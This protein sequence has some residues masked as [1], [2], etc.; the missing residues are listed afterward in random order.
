M[1]QQLIFLL[2]VQ[3]CKQVRKKP[4]FAWR[5]CSNGL[6]AGG[7]QICKQASKLLDGNKDHMEIFKAQCNR[8]SDLN[9]KESAL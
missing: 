6:G 4:H 7:N 8:D 2:G 1:C 5:L 9:G 3:G